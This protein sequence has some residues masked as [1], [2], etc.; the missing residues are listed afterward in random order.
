MDTAA[1]QKMHNNNHVFV[2]LFG[3]DE[4]RVYGRVGRRVGG[5]L[6]DFVGGPSVHIVVAAAKQA[7]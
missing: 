4:R 1:S 3:R 7:L 6:S 5:L 2:L